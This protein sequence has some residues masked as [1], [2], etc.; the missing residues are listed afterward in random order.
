MDWFHWFLLGCLFLSGF[1]VGKLWRAAHIYR[2][3]SVSA[4]A[5]ADMATEELAKCQIKRDDWH[6][7][8]DERAAEIARLR[9]LT[10]HYNWGTS[11]PPAI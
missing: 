8:A 6:K 7:I 3:A 5:M 4:I 9:K 1:A 10:E 11:A 2:C